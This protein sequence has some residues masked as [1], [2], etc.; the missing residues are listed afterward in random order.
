MEE[1][2]QEL[3]RCLMLKQ[4]SCEQLAAELQ[5]TKQE[6]EAWEYQCICNEQLVHFVWYSDFYVVH[7]LCNEMFYLLGYGSVK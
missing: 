4:H 2:K 7:I 6:A 1:E 5:L 3:E